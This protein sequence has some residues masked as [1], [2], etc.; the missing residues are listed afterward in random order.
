LFLSPFFIQP[1]LL[2]SCSGNN[3]ELVLNLNECSQPDIE[4]QYPFE[5]NDVNNVDS[6]E[7][8]NLLLNID[9]RNDIL[10]TLR[11][12]NTYISENDYDIEIS[13]SSFSSEINI[14]YFNTYIL[15]K[16]FSKYCIN[17]QT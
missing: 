16:P 7:Y 13:L 11:G 4:R 17:S 5:C 8:N 15:S 12:Y 9:F 1:F 10:S 2:L 14:Y 6:K 3:K